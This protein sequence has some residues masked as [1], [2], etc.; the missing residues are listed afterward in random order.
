MAQIQLFNIVYIW[1]SWSFP[2]EIA[3][4]AV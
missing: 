4:L 2:I 1:S 3:I